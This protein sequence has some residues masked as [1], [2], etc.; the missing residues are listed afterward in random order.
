M[1][2]TDSYMKNMRLRS[3]KLPVNSR[4]RY[5]PKALIKLMFCPFLKYIV[6]CSFY[7]NFAILKLIL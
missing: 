5:D 6:V 1:F 3:A 2:A 4:V 7:F